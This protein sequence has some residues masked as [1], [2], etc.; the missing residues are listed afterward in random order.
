MSSSSTVSSESNNKNLNFADYALGGV[1]YAGHHWKSVSETSG[2]K[3]VYHLAMMI[4]NVLPIISSVVIFINRNQY[5]DLKNKLSDVSSERLDELQEGYEDG[6]LESNQLSGTT[7]TTISQ[8][9]TPINSTQPSLYSL[10]VANKKI[11]V[12]NF[13]GKRSEKRVVE[14]IESILNNNFVESFLSQNVQ[15][16]LKEIQVLSLACE[17]DGVQLLHIMMTH[18]RIKK[19]LSEIILSENVVHKV[20][21]FRLCNLIL[22]SYDT[23]KEGVE[24]KKKHYVYANKTDLKWDARFAYL[25]KDEQDAFNL[26]LN[27]RINEFCSLFLSKSNKKT[28]F[29][30]S[31]KTE[32]CDSFL[33]FDIQKA[34]EEWLTI[35]N[36]IGLFHLDNIKQMRMKTL[37]LTI[38]TNPFR[39]LEQLM[40]DSNTRKRFRNIFGIYNG[41]QSNLRSQDRKQY[42]LC[43]SL[44]QM[45]I[46]FKAGAGVR[47]DNNHFHRILSLEDRNKNDPFAQCKKAAENFLDAIGLQDKKNALLNDLEKNTPFIDWIVKVD[48]LLNQKG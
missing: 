26:I 7:I 9:G 45:Y 27:G 16:V 37:E 30:N 44:V 24:M 40:K 39:L 36:G 33:E 14:E 22:K 20:S 38:Y 48:R 29:L 21:I 23:L 10:D 17:I 46:L 32:I 28:D 18:S 5:V 3:K 6:P 42:G 15:L 13:R 4:L 19:I 11:T 8:S 2:Y 25:N 12:Y 43:N 35:A 31:I 41:T 1:V 34:S 47:I